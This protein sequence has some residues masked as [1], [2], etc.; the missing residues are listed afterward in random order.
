MTKIQRDTGN[1]FETLDS[2]K[3]GEIFRFENKTSYDY[4]ILSNVQIY[5]VL[6][7][8]KDSIPCVKIATGEVVWFKPGIEV[9]KAKKSNLRL[10]Y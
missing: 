4:M 6:N 5:P 2:L 9:I 1:P 10:E 3:M 7:L 8:D